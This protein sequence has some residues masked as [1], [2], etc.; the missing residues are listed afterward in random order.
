[1]TASRAAQ[2][3]IPS[4]QAADWSLDRD[5]AV[6]RHPPNVKPEL[7]ATGPNQVWSWDIERHEALPNRAVVKGH[8]DGLVAAS[9][10]TLR[11]A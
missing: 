3:P 6:P 11:A 7:V 5:A 10:L 8:R 1:M 4:A 2:A 9:S